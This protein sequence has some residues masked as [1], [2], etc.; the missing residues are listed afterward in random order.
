MT[1]Q[2][3]NTGTLNL[4]YMEGS[5]VGPPVLLLHGFATR[6]QSFNRIIPELAKAWHLYALDLRGHGK[7]G[8]ANAYRIQDY[9]PDIAAFIR[10]CIKEQ[11]IIFGH[12]YG[13]M[14]GM[15][16]A[17]SNPELV[18][19]LIVGD[20]FLSAEAFKEY[21][22][23]HIEKSIYW[24]DLANTKGI[25][26]I[27]AKLNKELIP[28]PNQEG[29]VPAYQVYGENNRYFEFMATTYSQLDPELLTANIERL[30]ESSIGYQP[31]QILPKIKC[32]VLL[33]QANPELGGLM[34]DNDL[35]QALGI[36]PVAQHVRV[37]T[38]H[39]LHI[40]DRE[41]VL[42]VLVPFLQVFKE[43]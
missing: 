26:N 13:G 43:S 23:Q 20:S 34:R 24:R 41:A 14:I 31:D 21:D 18:K 33:L 30:S 22:N 27:I 6:W 11:T 7:S 8:R 5:P 10:D 16:L 32:P 35:R 40:D 29:L 42:K 36:L 38:G 28:S 12:S 37:N 25:E 2:T 15:M 4:N 19:G 3:F 9:V 17:A 39:F 1:E